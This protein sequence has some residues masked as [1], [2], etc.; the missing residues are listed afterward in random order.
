[1]GMNA[2]FIVKKI[3][4]AK[5]VHYINNKWGFSDMVSQQS[6]GLSDY[7][8]EMQNKVFYIQ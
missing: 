8:I 6:N 4:K 2:A 1:M 3:I 5:P 7:R